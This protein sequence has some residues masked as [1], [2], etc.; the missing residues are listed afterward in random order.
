MSDQ[1]K[2]GKCLC[3]EVESKYWE[4]QTD[5]KET[6][7][8][9][10]QHFHRVAPSV[11]FYRRITTFGHLIPTAGQDTHRQHASFC[12]S[13]FYWQC[14]QHNLRTAGD[15]Q[16]KPRGKINAAPEQN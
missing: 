16:A 13:A 15:Y 1:Q 2:S 8:L 3:T 14:P 9:K 12:T 7:L 6:Q 4:I 11:T 10:T 5:R